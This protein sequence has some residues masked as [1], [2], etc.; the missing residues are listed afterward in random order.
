[1]LL[2]NITGI[3]VRTYAVFNFAN[4]RYPGEPTS[5]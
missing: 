3:T 5:T 2:D 1:M 4:L